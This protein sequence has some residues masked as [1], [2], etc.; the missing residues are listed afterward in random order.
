MKKI[1]ILSM[2]AMATATAFAQSVTYNHD[3]SKQ[4][5]IT[6]MET[7]GGSLTPEFYYWMLHNSYRKSAAEK[8]KLGF[9]TLA[10]I[11][12]YNQVDDAEKIDSA[13]TK[14]TEIE[15]LNVADRQIDLAWLAE[16]SKI[17]GQ[18]EKM[19]ANIG[20]IVPTGGT[21]NDK[22]RWEELYN[23]Y[24]CAVKAT[25]DAYMPNAQ[26]KKEYLR[27]YADLT[28]QNETLLKYLVQLNTKNQ[29]ANLLA[30]TNDRVVHKGNIISDAKSRWQENMKGVRGTAGAEDE[31]G[32]NGDGEESVNR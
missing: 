1:T 9:R 22:R 14:R 27:I 28:A 15:A 6:V 2:A 8:N 24:R 16:S 21:I 10:G 7:G 4:N 25:K 19:K 29:T 17:N 30:A 3:S 31:D 20:H 32:D 23:M 26:R 5:Q 13:L 18:L 12:L 11:N